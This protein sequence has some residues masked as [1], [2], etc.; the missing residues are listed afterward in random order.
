MA[1]SGKTALLHEFTRRALAA[2]PELVAASGSCNAQAGVGDPYLP[3]RDILQILSGD[4]EARRAGHSITWE[5]AGRLWELLPECIRALVEQGPDLLDLFVPG[6]PLLRRAEALALSSEHGPTRADS[7]GQLSALLQQRRAGRP[8][9]QADLFEQV[10]RVLRALAAGQPLLLVIDDL[11]WADNGTLGLLFHLGRR[12]GESRILLLGA[13]RS[14]EV[15]LGRDGQRHP[16]EGVCNQFEREFGTLVV[17]IAADPGR[18]FINALLDSEPNDL[19]DSFRMAL[20]RQ[21]QGHPLFTVE[22]LRGMVERGDL[23]QDE[24]GC[25]R[26]GARL[27][28]E[29][30]PARVGAIIAERIG[31]LPGEW[32]ALLA[33][34]SIQGEAFLAEV[35]AGV[36]DE[37]DEA[38][39]TCL[40]GALRRQR[41]VISESLRRLHGQRLSCYRFGHSMFQSY[42]YGHLDPITKVRWHEA[43][44]TK[45][46][47][48]YGEDTAEVAVE[49]AWHFERAGLPDR[50]ADYLLEAGG[51]AMRL[52][53]YQEPAAGF[54]R[55]LALLSTLPH[56]PERMQREVRLRLA[57]TGS[58]VPLHHLSDPIRMQAVTQTLLVCRQSGGMPAIYALLL[59]ASACRDQC[60]FER[61]IEL[62]E[63]L[64]AFR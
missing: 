10:T 37:S 48:L 56:T 8:A 64:L 7:A 16:L 52:A 45:L 43:I 31:S 17:D 5:H 34:A 27:D 2:H 42:L 55:G 11:Q 26:V 1:G 51:R 22:I 29:R 47:E 49:L 32:Q 25:W 39:A 20:E 40:G 41:L 28:W 54:E 18:D 4:I 44:G 58:L 50:A 60:D 15:A 63:Q 46:A 38:V 36:L 19:P 62:G 13:Y 21:T 24:H 59:E 23:V 6:A 9:G 53:A 3:F 35:V 33:V 12:L 14:D 57:L 61:T 30:L